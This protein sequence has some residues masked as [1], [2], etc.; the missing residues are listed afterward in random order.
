MEFCGFTPVMNKYRDQECME[1]YLNQ[2]RVE[3][4][5][6]P[7]LPPLG[8]FL[9]RFA[10]HVDYLAIGVHSSPGWKYLSAD[11]IHRIQVDRGLYL[12]SDAK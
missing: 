7:G 8:E 2:V 6:D 12:I 11:T 10:P 5:Q 3:R 4:V 1:L 9:P